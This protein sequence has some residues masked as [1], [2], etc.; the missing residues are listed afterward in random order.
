M[1]KIVTLIIILAVL[2]SGYLIL[3]KA[4]EPQSFIPPSGFATSKW[5]AESMDELQ[6]DFVGDDDLT[7]EKIDGDWQANGLPADESLINDFFEGLKKVSITSK[8][9]EN[10]EN[11]DKFDVGEKGIK[12]TMLNGGQVVQEL[13]FG[14]S[15]GGSNTYVRIPDQNDVYVL[16]G[17]SRYLITD[18]ISQWIDRK[19][20]T[21][22]TQDMRKVSFSRGY[23]NWDL[24]KRSDDEWVLS[25]PGYADFS[26]TDEN[27]N[28][29]VLGQISSMYAM[30]IA[31]G[32]EREEIVNAGAL[33]ATATIELGTSDELYRTVD[34]KL[35][36]APSIPTTDPMMPG[37]PESGENQ[38]QERYLLLRSDDGLGYFV[39]K[40]T[41]DE[42]FK[43]YA[44]MK[45]K[46]TPAPEIETSGE[47]VD[48]PD[49]V[50]EMPQ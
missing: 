20:S 28:K 32:Q 22:E 6:F 46:L 38:M 39:N 35:Y 2:I 13:I 41:I 27:K 29:G 30:S 45:E 15:A 37:G 23:I 25:A 12:L 26:A 17:L 50:F 7:L 3:K 18:E 9:S 10:S 24:T 44:Q 19:V 4:N 48:I 5:N 34:W 14:K 33:V 11:H 1:K 40:V 49:P 31:T 43:N 8:V 36:P 47:P 21:F 16:T 42:A